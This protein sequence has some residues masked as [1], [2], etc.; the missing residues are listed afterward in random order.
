MKLLKIATA[1]A[2]L[3]MS[4][5]IAQAQDSGFYGAIGATSYDFDFYGVEGKLGYN[6]N[7][8]FAIEGQAGTGLID[9]EEELGGFEFETNI[10]YNVGLFGVVRAPLGQNFEV[11][12]RGGY[13]AT[14]LSTE[15]EFD[16]DDDNGLDDD[17]DEITETISAD[18]FAYGGGIQYFFN[19]RDGLRLEYT[20]YDL[21]SVNGVDAGTAD[22]VSLSYTRKF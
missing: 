20:G 14:E 3:S 16:D 13:H 22:A 1:S 4:A 10:D 17:D 11:F 21:G 18:G 19:G 15:I 7:E 5:G 8:F 9:N 2:L 12:A 6:I